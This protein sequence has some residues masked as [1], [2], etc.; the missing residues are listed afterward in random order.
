MFHYIITTKDTTR[1]LTFVEYLDILAPKSVEEI[2]SIFGLK[3]IE[4]VR[5]YTIKQINYTT[6]EMSTLKEY[7]R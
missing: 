5:S 6:G 7:K 4:F 1:D 2:E 3:D